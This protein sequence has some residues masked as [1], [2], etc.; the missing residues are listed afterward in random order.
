V[1]TEETHEEPVLSPL[2]RVRAKQAQWQ[3]A[4]QQLATRGGRSANPT[5]P[6]HY[7]RHR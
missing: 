1:E 3:A 5:A 6:R 7:N 4:R 2:E